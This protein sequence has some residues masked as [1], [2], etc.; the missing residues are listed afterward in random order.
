MI[1][2]D[3]PKQSSAEISAEVSAESSAETEI[4]VIRNEISVGRHYKE[5]SFRAKSA[6]NSYFK[7]KIEIFARWAFAHNEYQITK[8]SHDPMFS[9]FK[10]GR[11]NVHNF[12]FFH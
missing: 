2:G 5:M 12:F 7:K 6:R 4:S 9:L 8:V 3:G 11:D 10:S 1:C